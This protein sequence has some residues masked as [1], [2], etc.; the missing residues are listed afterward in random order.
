[1]RNLQTIVIGD[2]MTLSRHAD[3]SFSWQE[4]AS[5]R[6]QMA[7]AEAHRQ[8]TDKAALI[9]ER[10]DDLDQHDQNHAEFVTMRPNSDVSAFTS[11]ESIE[12]E[13]DG[14]EDSE[15]FWEGDFDYEVEGFDNEDFSSQ[16]KSVAKKSNKVYQ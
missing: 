1:M 15:A 2:T 14:D 6:A 3:I 13:S 12:W 9:K 5:G 8:W 10:Q 4:V 11:S 7:A 16:S